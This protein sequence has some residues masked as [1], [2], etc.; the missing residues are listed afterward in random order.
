MSA[1][2]FQLMN[3][4]V[5]SKKGTSEQHGSLLTEMLRNLKELS[6][7]LLQSTGHVAHAFNL[8]TREAGK[9]SCEFKAILVYTESSRSIR[10]T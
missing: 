10:V 9:I 1:L 5:V 2:F 4:E 3:N 7:K 8:S 6:S